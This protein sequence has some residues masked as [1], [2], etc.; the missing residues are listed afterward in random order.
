MP[1]ALVHAKYDAALRG[2]VVA[3]SIEQQKAWSQLSHRNAT[4]VK[5]E[6][7]SNVCGVAAVTAG[8]EINE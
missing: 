2:R 1:L 3:R 6:I 5:K 7:N 8:L 4:P